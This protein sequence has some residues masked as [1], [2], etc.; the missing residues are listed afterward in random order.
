MGSIGK[1]GGFYS[2]DHLYNN[3][4]SLATLHKSICNDSRF[5][6]N[7]QRSVEYERKAS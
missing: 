1:E 2:I 3:S 6:E 4:M 5:Q 7:S